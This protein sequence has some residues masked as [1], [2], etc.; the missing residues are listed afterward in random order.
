MLDRSRIRRVTDHF[1]EKPWSPFFHVHGDEMN[2]KSAAVEQLFR[3]IRPCFRV[4]VIQGSFNDFDLLVFLWSM[5]LSE[6]DS[7]QIGT[8]V[9]PWS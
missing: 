8:P 7:K 5:S 4:P 2:I 3:Y 1:Q 9:S 6:D